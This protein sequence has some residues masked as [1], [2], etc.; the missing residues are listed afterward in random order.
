[1][2]HRGLVAAVVAIAAAVIL[3]FSSYYIVYPSEWTLVLQLGKPVR[4]APDPD[5]QGALVPGAGSGLY[6]KIPF[7][8]N[9]VY[10]DKRVLNFD[11][12]SEEVPTLD[13]IQ[14]IVSA[15]A[16][17]QI[18]N[19]LLFYQTVNNEDGVQARLRP[20]ISS[21]LRR[22]LGDVPMATILTSH[23]ADLMKQIT[24]QVDM[25]ARQFGIKVIDVRMKRVDLTPDNAEAIY[26]QM[27]TQRQQLATEYRAKGQADAVAMRA[28]ADKQQVIILANAHQQSDILRGQGDAEA[29]SI[30]A[31]AYNKDPAF[32]DFFR[33][34]LAMSTALTG[35]TT[36]YIG[37]PGGDFFRYFL[38][39][40]GAKPP[41]PGTPPAA[42][43]TP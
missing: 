15:Y 24:Q 5:T 29:T 34:L 16:R 4:V 11:A 37:P 13:Q 2:T 9:V 1:M 12:P 33:S 38:S 23:R 32:Y 35:E 21:N 14:V 26:K 6:F 19:P 8:Q 28:D 25:E 36:T 10:L 3:L 43:T 40:D 31:E 17:F 18:V 39:R 22:A 30:Y 7:V 27:Q 42:T 20:I 41:V